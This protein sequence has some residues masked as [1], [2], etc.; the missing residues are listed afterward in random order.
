MESV[1]MALSAFESEE[2]GTADH[3]PQRLALL[4][5]GLLMLLCGGITI[6]ADAADPRDVVRTTGAL[7][8]IAGGLEI[9][10]GI[11]HGRLEQTEG[12]L[13]IILGIISL[14]VA[15]YFL[16]SP[17]YTAARFAGLLTLWLL[18][19]GGID[20]LAAFLTRDLFSEE[21]RLLRASVDLVLGLVSYIG[22]GTTAWWERLLGWPSTAAHVTFLFA[23]VSLAAAGLFLIGISRPR[24]APEEMS[25]E[26][27]G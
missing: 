2:T 10:A 24:Y 14:A 3:R 27:T 5:C 12:R 23:G 7:L 15:A 22:L 18:L 6:I 11:A 4:L 19:R 16:L 25:T 9:V 13:D 21:G 8:L 20:M 1:T 17:A 26:L